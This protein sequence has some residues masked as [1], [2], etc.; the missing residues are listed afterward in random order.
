MYGDIWG[1][2]I[3]KDRDNASH[4]PLADDNPEQTFHNEEPGPV[5]SGGWGTVGGE[6]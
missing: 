5:H 2:R 1:V 4:Y 3:R 6:V